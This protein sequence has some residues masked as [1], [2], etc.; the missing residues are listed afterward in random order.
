MITSTTLASAT[1][2]IRVLPGD[3]TTLRLRGELDMACTDLV[4]AAAALVPEYA[5]VVTVDLSDLTFI[6]G[7]G[8]DTLAA[9]HAA[10]L[11]RGR[12]VR[13][14]R[15]Q[16]C[17]WRVLDLVGMGSLLAVARPPVGRL[18]GEHRPVWS[19]TTPF[20]WGLG[21]GLTRSER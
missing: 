20:C 5:A 9:F 10:Q 6:D 11:V 13:L 18:S 14:T 1:L 21:T 7:T 2:R 16:P 3:L 15:P 19:R 12:K 8:A 4:H 17:V